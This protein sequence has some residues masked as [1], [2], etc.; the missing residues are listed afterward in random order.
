MFASKVRKRRVQCM[1]SSRWRWQQ[2]NL[3]RP[4]HSG[5]HE[6]GRF[7]LIAL[8][9]PR[10]GLPDE[11]AGISIHF[12]SGAPNYVSRQIIHADGGMISVL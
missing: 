6:K 7:R 9:V 8:T 10:W 5:W 4:S 11:F 2:N 1:R 3:L 12:A